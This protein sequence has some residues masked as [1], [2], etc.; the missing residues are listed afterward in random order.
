MGGGPEMGDEITQPAQSAEFLRAK[1]LQEARRRGSQPTLTAPQVTSRRLWTP[2][3]DEQDPVVQKA[4]LE[5]LVECA[6][7]AIS[8]LDVKHRITRINSE[9]TQLFGFTAEEALGKR[10]S[11]LIVPAERSA[12]LDWIR[13]S[14]LRGQKIT[15]ETR[16]QRKDG[17]LVD[18]SVSCAAVTVKGEHVGYYVLYRDIEE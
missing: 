10:P 14:V 2:A 9:F 6:P 15:L 5:Q 18:V 3:W 8:I 13:E 17:S 7:E 16:R 12:E 1:V 4:Y 11:E